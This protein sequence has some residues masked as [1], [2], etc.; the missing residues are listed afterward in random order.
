VRARA[1][2]LAVLVGTLVLSASLAAADSFTPVTLSITVASVARLHAPLKVTVKVGADP[3]VLDTRE[4]PMRIEV[5]LASECGSNFQTSPGVTLLNRQL[6][7]QPATGRAY[8]ATATGSGRPNSYG[9]QTVCTFLEDTDV[10]REYA[11]DESIQVKVSKPCTVAG[12]R[13]DAVHSALARA[14]RELRRARGRAARRRLARLVA[15]RQLRLTRDRR[16]GVAA[17]GPGVPL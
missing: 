1:A 8:S 13:Y 3:G 5:K 15:K 4:G 2:V 6:N 9:T 7:P 17:C 12:S 14:K 10:G 16:L 11:N